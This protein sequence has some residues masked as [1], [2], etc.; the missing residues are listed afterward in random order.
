[1]AVITTE[2]NLP[3]TCPPQKN[4]LNH[5]ADLW[6]TFWPR[7]DRVV[8]VSEVIWL[9][10]LPLAWRLSVLVACRRLVIWVLCFS[11]LV[12]RGQKA[13]RIG[14]RYEGASS[15][16]DF[17]L[18]TSWNCGDVRTEN[19]RHH[20]FTKQRLGFRR[21]IQVLKN[22]QESSGDRV[23]GKPKGNENRATCS[24]LDSYSWLHQDDH[25]IVLEEGRRNS[26]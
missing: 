7:K 5:G 3:L 16:Y 22:M 20:S 4:W 18:E 12:A 25:L 26:G 8:K 19:R 1:M 17:P 6:K 24:P 11:K 2:K 9:L 21:F 14:Q 10:W 15:L 23:M 13:R